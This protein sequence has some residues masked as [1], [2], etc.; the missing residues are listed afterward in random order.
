MTH[1]I[2]RLR[3]QVGKPADEQLTGWPEEGPPPSYAHVTGGDTQMFYDAITADKAEAFA[4]RLAGSRLE[5]G[6]RIAPA[7]GAGAGPAA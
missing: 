6:V 3:T 1:G 2:D 7:S 5:K 4:A